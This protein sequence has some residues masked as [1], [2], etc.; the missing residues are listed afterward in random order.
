LPRLKAVRQS[1]RAVGNWAAGKYA[2]PASRIQLRDSLLEHFRAIY[3]HDAKLPSVDEWDALL[4][5]VDNQQ[6]TPHQLILKL[7]KLLNKS[8]QGDGNNVQKT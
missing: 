5:Q 3:G 1:M 2:D 8:R 6:N 4:N 7:L